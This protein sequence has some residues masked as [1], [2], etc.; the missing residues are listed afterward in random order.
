[1]H[2]MFELTLCLTN[3]KRRAPIDFDLSFVEVLD[4]TE[5]IFSNIKISQSI[6]TN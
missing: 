1:M 6:D 3:L 2:I 5:T 4:S